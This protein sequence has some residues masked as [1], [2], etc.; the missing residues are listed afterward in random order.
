MAEDI[1]INGASKEKSYHFWWVRDCI[2][3]IYRVFNGFM[4]SRGLSLPS[5]FWTMD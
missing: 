3:T 5:H 4:G 1:S 2:P